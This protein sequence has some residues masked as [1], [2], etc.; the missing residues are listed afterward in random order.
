MKLKLI[1]ASVV[2][3]ESLSEFKILQSTIELFY[4]VTWFIASDKYVYDNLRFQ[5][6]INCFPVILEQPG[7]HGIDSA[8]QNSL[9]MSLMMKKFSVCHRALLLHNYVLLLDADIIFVAPFPEYI[10][11]EIIYSSVDAIVSPHY[12]EDHQ[13]ES[14]VGKYNGGMICVK[15][16]NFL[17]QWFQLSLKYKE[18]NW[19][20]EQQPIEFAAQGFEVSQFPI[21]CNIGWW[22]MN[23]D[24]THARYESL[25]LKDECIN[26]INQIAVCFHTHTIK[27]LPYSN[28]GAFLVERL[29]YILSSSKNPLHSTILNILSSTLVNSWISL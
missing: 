29:I 3:R 22:R 25:I 28:Y 19:Y 15:S 8:E 21:Y 9:H 2:S 6:N 16:L 12:S 26:F 10:Y 23:N 18:N 5:I 7:T 17:N 11:K 24:L 27:R 14:K 1:C 13:L 20:Y 4:C